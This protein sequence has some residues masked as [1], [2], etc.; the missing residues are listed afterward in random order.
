MDKD[1]TIY[2]VS[3]VNVGSTAYMRYAKL[4]MRQNRERMGCKVAI[5]TDLD[6]RPQDDG[7]FIQADESAAF[8]SITEEIKVTDYPDIKWCIARQW[9]LEWCLYKSALL[10][11]LFKSAAAEIHSG[12]F[13]NG[14]NLVEDA[15]YEKGIMNMLRQYKVENGKHISVSKFKKVEV[16]YQLAAKINDATGI[17]FENMADDDYAK[18]LIDAIKHVCS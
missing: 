12:T 13:K 18:Y 11:D 10:G 17:D 8:T 6:V 7:H 14:T 1:F 4:F 16:A 9:T 5:V 15:V 2:E 3:V